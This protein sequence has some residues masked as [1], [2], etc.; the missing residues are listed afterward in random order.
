M[1]FLAIYEVWKYM[2]FS[3]LII[4]MQNMAVGI[5][6]KIVTPIPIDPSAPNCTRRQKADFLSP[7][8]KPNKI[9]KISSCG[10]I[11][12]PPERLELSTY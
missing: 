6:D 2:M 3:H 12:A 5:M 8:I 10:D 1:I 4:D 11:C 9:K 7:H